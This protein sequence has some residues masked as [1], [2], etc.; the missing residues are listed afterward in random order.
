MKK[1]YLVI[2]SAFFCSISVTSCNQ[3]NP[4]GDPLPS[5]KE[6]QIKKTILEYLNRTSQSIPVEDRIAVFDMDGTIACEAPLWFEMYAAVKGL[7]QQSAKDPGLLRF[8]EYQYARKL[9]IDP[10]DTS[11]M[12]HWAYPVDYIDSMIWKAYAGVDNETYVDSARAYLSRTKDHRYNIL[13]S[14]MFYQPMLELISYLKEKQFTVYVV[15]G[16]IQGVIWSVCPQIL[17]CDRA[18]LIGTTQILT[19]SYKPGGHKTLFVIGKGIFPPEDDKNGKSMNIYSHIGKVPVFAFG[20]T[21]GDFGMMHLA[22][23][24]KY[25]NIEFLLNHDDPV[26]EYAYPPYH[27]A[28]VPHWKDTLSFNHWNLVN[29]AG[30]FKTVWM[31]K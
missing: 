28:A 14:K 8:K 11:V 5:W 27:G 1:L 22:S 26:R 15:S 13:L 18:H 16:S 21:V 19:P 4:Q 25:P 20:N 24:S 7:N 2:L 29:M 6:T 17:N 31:M 23:T 10:A 30:E 9:A 12:N 3:V